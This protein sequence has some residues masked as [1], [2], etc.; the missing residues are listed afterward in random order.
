[1]ARHAPLPA[2]S[3]LR[4]NDE[5]MGFAVRQ[6]D[7]LRVLSLVPLVASWSDVFDDDQSF[8]DIVQSSLATEKIKL[9]KRP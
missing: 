1:M 3:A 6:I 5:V 2:V 4:Q 7:F 9:L 8:L